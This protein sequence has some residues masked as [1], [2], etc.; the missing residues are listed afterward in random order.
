MNYRV[1]A[2]GFLSGPTLQSNGTANA[3]FYDQRLAIE[4]VKTHIAKF[5]GDPEQITI[6]GESAGGGSVMHQITAFGGQMPVAFQRAIPQSPAFVPITSN[7]EQE[8]TFQDFLALLNVSSLQAT[9]NLPSSALIEANFQQIVSAPYG[10]Y[11]YGPAVDGIFVPSL[12]GTLLAEDAFAKDVH[13]MAGHNSD[14]GLLFADPRISNDTEFEQYIR[15]RFPDIGSE[16]VEY[17]LNVLYPARYDGSQP[18]MSFMAR[19]V[20]FLSDVFFTCNTNFLVAAATKQ[21]GYPGSYTYDFA[22]PPGIHGQDLAYTFYDG[23]STSVTSELVAE[24]LQ[25]YIVSFAT[26][27]VPSSHAANGVT[28]PSY[29]GKDQAVVLNV[30]GPSVRKDPTA[31]ARCA[32][33][34]KAL[35]F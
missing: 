26:T 23:P 18:Y 32:W 31:N 34:Q 11:V 22:V 16:T 6:M 15:S 8:T 10:T 9:R 12:P 14:E 27:G 35:Y 20:L 33:W 25:Q 21:S 29:G 7:A 3:G 24:I 13:V 30:T 28:F 17:I 19:Y 5:G 2:F 1:G 4:W